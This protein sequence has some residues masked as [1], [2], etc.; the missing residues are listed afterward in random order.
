MGYEIVPTLQSK[1]SIIFGPARNLVLGFDTFDSHLEY[2]LIDMRETT[3][4]NMF[5]VIAISNI[6]TGIIMPDLF[7]YATV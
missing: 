1:N 3:G 5:R 7:V 2:K 6:A 4:D